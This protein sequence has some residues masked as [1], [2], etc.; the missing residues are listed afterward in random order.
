M[1][2]ATI[3]EMLGSNDGT[4][5]H[6]NKGLVSKKGHY[7]ADMAVFL[8]EDIIPY[9]NPS[10][11]HLRLATREYRPVIFRLLVSKQRIEMTMVKQSA[12]L[13]SDRYHNLVKSKLHQQISYPPSE[14]DPGLAKEVKLAVGRMEW[15]DILRR[16]KLRQIADTYAHKC[17]VQLEIAR[18]RKDEEEYEEWSQ[19]FASWSEW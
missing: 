18:R 13:G 6:E 8:P 1:A 5:P 3:I 15:K 16:K 4:H 9:G 14:Q 12:R 10:E 17:K 19:D 7:A 11:I 2:S